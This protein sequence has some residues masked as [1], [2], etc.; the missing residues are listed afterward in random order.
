MSLSID[1]GRSIERVFVEVFSN[2]AFLRKRAKRIEK[3]DI[4]VLEICFD[5]FDSDAYTLDDVAVQ[6]LRKRRRGLPAQAAGY[7]CGQEQ[8]QCVRRP[9]PPEQGHETAGR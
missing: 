4:S 7:P 5:G 1:T 8:G 3:H 2:R 6:G 9:V